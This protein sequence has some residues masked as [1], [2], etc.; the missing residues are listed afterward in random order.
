M[1][2]SYP[3]AAQGRDGE[4]RL[5]RF[6]GFPTSENPL[7]PKFRERPFHALR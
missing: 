1:S 5:W 3:S 7:G 4:S 2:Y 6:R